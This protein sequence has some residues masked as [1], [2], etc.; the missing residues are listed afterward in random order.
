MVSKCCKAHM[1]VEGSACSKYFVCS[2]CGR[3]CDGI[4]GEYGKEADNGN[5]R[6]KENP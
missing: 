4:I 3:P 2:E 5:V 1:E 6:S